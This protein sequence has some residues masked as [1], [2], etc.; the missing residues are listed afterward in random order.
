LTLQSSG[1]KPSINLN[2]LIKQ[3]MHYN[4]TSKI[5]QKYFL[6]WS[7][8]LSF[9]FTAFL[10]NNA[11]AQQNLTLYNMEMVPQRLYA[12]PAF[13]P[14]NKIYIGLPILSSEYINFSNS[15][16][17]YSDLI[18]HRGDSLYVDYNNMLS[19]LSKNNYISAAIQPD[20]L[21]FGFKI[22]EKNYFSFNITEKVNFRFRY[23]KNFMELIWKGNGGLLGEEVKLNFGV[24]FTH[25]R[26]YGIGYAREINDKLTVGGKVKYLYG[27]ENVWTE[28]SDISLTTDPNYYA[29]TAKSDIKIN[30]SGLDTS[31]FNNVNVKN[32]LF[33][34]KNNGFGIDLGGVY[35][36]NDKL[37]LSASVIDLGFI[38]WKDA[39]NNY[40][41]RDPNASF[42][43]EGMDINQLV[44]SDSTNNPAKKM[45][46]SLAKI[47]KID[48]V[49]NSYTTHLSSQIYIGG[50]Y[51]LAEK[52]NVG[53]LL[54]G[55]VFDKVIHPALALSYN[56]KVGNWL[57]FSLS[58]SMYNR[59]YNNVGL[60]LALGNGPV[61]FY[62]ISDNVLGAFF[63]QNTKNL[64]LN[65]GLNLTFG[66]G[67]KD[68]D[69][70]GV[71][72]K[73]DDCVDVA[74]L[75]E[76]KGCP[77]KDGDGIADK[78]DACPEE[79][80]LAKL[81]GCPDKDADGIADKEDACADIAGLAE[82]KGCPDKDID[83][84]AD[85]DDACPDE[86]G[87]AELKGCPDKDGDKVSD[88]ED[89]C[90]DVPG[91][92]ALKG[93]PDKDGD[94]VEDKMDLCPDKPGTVS[95]KGC[96]ETR[97]LLIDL[98]G[99]TLGTAVRAKDGSFKFEGV[100]FD[101][102]MLFQLDGEHIDTI[103]EITI[104]VGGETRKATRISSEFPYRYN[105]LKS[106]KNKL[107]KKETEDVAVKLDKKEEEV[108][109]KA[110]NNLEF[111]SGKDIIKESSFAS[112]D[113]LA[114]LMAKKPNWRLKISGHTDN[115]GDAVANLK[116][117]EKRAEAI[118]KYLV[119][120]GIAADRFKV[121][122]FGSS[123]PIADN[124]TEAGRQQNRR[125]EM[126]IIE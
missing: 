18:R 104:I 97:L 58:Y 63:P 8:A 1:Y 125:V 99:K 80:G 55:Q 85:K 109:K 110:F 49:H 25:Y 81:K 107:E 66:K 118:K 70:D 120:K 84:I 38:K 2:G 41:S 98:S 23:P 21:S 4:T 65:F 60:G 76:L 56:Q 123:K 73:K 62:M 46:D 35:K 42:T 13:I 71:A 100:P 44:N 105:F 86:K 124:A 106:E 37:T 79:K 89:A 92:V 9:L 10:F 126:Q 83:G 17:K 31:S 101:E 102:N 77:D 96:P 28:R 114:G 20:L 12:N 5:L 121:E 87:L 54:Y 68:T 40:Q 57:N 43:Y 111:A 115:K 26:E 95:N 29:V 45:T 11:T 74:G 90:P 39:V 36:F 6:I 91:V 64:H 22:K 75:K 53:A 112:L 116:L 61:Q 32:Y 78:D 59:S 108:L 122:W 52:I 3:Y 93:C 88:K 82:L 19:K 27:M 16:F 30:T 47:F 117:S 48:T 94:G 103:T 72:D 33:K 69:K 50:N 51:K 119:S 7:L 14:S 34:K 15:G 24:N 113:E 67:G